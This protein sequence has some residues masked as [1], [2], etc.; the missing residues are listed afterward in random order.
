MAWPLWAGMAPDAEH[1]GAAARA[2]LAPD[3]RCPW[4]VRSTSALHELYSN[5]NCITPYS[6][7][8]ESRGCSVWRQPSRALLHF[9]AGNWRGPIWINVN[10]VLAY[11]LHAAGLRDEAL[12]LASDVTSLLAADLRRT[13]AWH[14]NYDA[15]T[16]VG[17]GELVGVGLAMLS[18]QGV[19][20]LC[21]FTR[22][23]QLEYAGG[24]LNS[25]PQG[26]TRSLCAVARALL[27]LSCVR[28]L[29]YLVL[30]VHEPL[31]PLRFGL[32]CLGGYHA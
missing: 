4:G 10:C 15:E 20:P 18:G 11:A 29:E 30:L 26:G 6:A 7:C 24:G 16:G 8:G 19:S 2:V 13:G 12:S 14:E 17:L 5:E 31:L 22:V 28:A 32:I 25:E 3:M 27:L 1:A 9:P 21:S 23:S